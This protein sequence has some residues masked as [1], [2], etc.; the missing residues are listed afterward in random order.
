MCHSE[1][2]LSL[3]ENEKAP[4]PSLIFVIKLGRSPSHKLK[5]HK[6]PTLPLQHRPQQPNPLTYPT[7]L[8]HPK[9]ETPTS[10][11]NLRAP[12]MTSWPPSIFNAIRRLRRQNL[13][14]NVP[15]VPYHTTQASRLALAVRNNLYQERDFLNTTFSIPVINRGTLL[16][17]ITLALDE[18]LDRL[19]R[20]LDTMFEVRVGARSRL[21]VRWERENPTKSSVLTESNLASTLRLLKVRGGVDRLYLEN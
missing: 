8:Q 3:P 15:P 21:W 17:I 20:D 6:Y 4:C 2:P 18:S 9:I 1:P 14:N 11:L 12:A 7:Y 13:N 5:W 19:M 16:G 10:T